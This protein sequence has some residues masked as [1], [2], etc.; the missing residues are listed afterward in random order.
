MPNKGYC[1]LEQK[2]YAH[3]HNHVK[4]T[5]SDKKKE[6]FFSKLHSSL[7]SFKLLIS[8]QT[9]LL[10]TIVWCTVLKVK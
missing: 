8:W 5:W 3:T 6:F 2:S 10:K 7:S 9:D 1:K 4:H